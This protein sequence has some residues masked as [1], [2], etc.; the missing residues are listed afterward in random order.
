MALAIV[1]TGEHYVADVL[2]GWI[3]AIA[4]FAAIRRLAVR[5]ARAA[6]R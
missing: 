4:S 6:G 1:Y 2:L 3:Y 5:L